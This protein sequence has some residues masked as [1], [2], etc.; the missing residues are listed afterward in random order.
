MNWLNKKL[1]TILQMALKSRGP[2]TIDQGKMKK[3][4]IFHE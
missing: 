1:M 2:I 4:D 3:K